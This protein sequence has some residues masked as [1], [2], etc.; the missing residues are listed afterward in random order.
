MKTCTEM[1]ITKFRR[2]LAGMEV[3]VAGFPWEWKRMSRD[4][5]GDGTK[6]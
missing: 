4:P 1:E 2:N 5:R 3:N 6:L